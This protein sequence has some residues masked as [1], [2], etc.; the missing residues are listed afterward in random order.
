[1]QDVASAL[2]YVCSLL[3]SPNV[4]PTGSHGSL[5]LGMEADT[6]GAGGSAA[7][8]AAP[9]Q[10]KTVRHPTIDAPASDEEAE[11]FMRRG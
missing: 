1:M 4:A 9:R 7:S 8:D 11:H 2:G 3:A 6:G 5:D 10:P